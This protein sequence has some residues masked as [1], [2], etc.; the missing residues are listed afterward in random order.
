MTILLAIICA[1][2]VVQ[3]GLIIYLAME[4]RYYS[5][6]CEELIKIMRQQNILIGDSGKLVDHNSDV[7]SD[8]I[9]TL[10]ELNNL[11]CE[12]DKKID[13]T[14][15]WITSVDDNIAE[16]RKD[17]QKILDKFDEDAYH[18][19]N[20]S[21]K[22]AKDIKTNS[23]WDSKDFYALYDELISKLPHHDTHLDDQKGDEANEQT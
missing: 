5:R 9:C 1:I 13:E 4:P 7:V 20:E 15:E 14:N 12:H 16:M 22:K 2:S 11:V 17:I 21:I 6:T 18:Y 3:F 8:L 23:I 10:H 19:I